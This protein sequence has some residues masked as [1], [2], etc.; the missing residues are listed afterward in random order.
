MNAAKSAPRLS[1]ILVVRNEA[2]CLERCLRSILPIADEIVVLDSGS[3]DGTVAIA[4]S[5]GARVEVAD[6]LGFGPQKNRALALARG[7]WVLSIDADERVTPELAASI[8]EA[9]DSTWADVN[10]YLIRFLATWCGKPVRFGDWRKRHLR[11]FRRE[12]ARFT[13]VPVHE[14]VICRPPH[15][16]LDGIMIHDTV[17]DE[18]E[19]RAKTRRYAELGALCLSAR[20]RGGL[21]AA[22]V[23]GGWALLRGF[24]LKGGFLDGA[25]GWK[26]ACATARC[27]WLRYYLAGRRSSLRSETGAVAVLWKST[28]GR[29]ARSALASARTTL[30]I[31]DSS[32]LERL[33]RLKEFI[34]MTVAL[35]FVALTAQLPGCALEYIR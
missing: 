11:L 31:A 3:D 35:S 4:R 12:G 1:A 34:L 10:G 21:S 19:A 14:G 28:P 5:F 2:H 26:V 15:A 30:G 13:N 32:A 24:V 16:T 22:F 33:E 8:R 9:V 17:A 29:L 7:E 18:D 6:W 23:H 20:G 25:A 27:T